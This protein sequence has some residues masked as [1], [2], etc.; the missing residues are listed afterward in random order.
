MQIFTAH[1]D[2]S[3][4]GFVKK[5]TE[6]SIKLITFVIMLNC[7]KSESSEARQKLSI[8]EKEKEENSNLFKSNVIS[9]ME[10]QMKNLWM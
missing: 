3:R 7:W 10:K 8:G 9:S 4:L 6:K 1:D 5:Y 2:K